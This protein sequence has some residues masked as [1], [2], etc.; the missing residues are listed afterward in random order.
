MI[1][2]S[3]NLP[4][5]P[6][7]YSDPELSPL[8]RHATLAASNL[9]GRFRCQERNVRQT[10]RVSFFQAL[11]R[12]DHREGIMDSWRS[13]LGSARRS[14]GK[15][16]PSFRPSRTARVVSMITRP[17]ATEARQPLR[18]A[19]DQR[20]KMRRSQTRSLATRWD[21]RHAKGPP[22]KEPTCTTR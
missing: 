6:T 19:E 21:N 15:L 17:A 11:P 5:R 2:T 13:A 16:Y 20:W 10:P 3:A 8:R 22:R 4:P 1:P 18:T 7:N 14:L 9:H 12:F